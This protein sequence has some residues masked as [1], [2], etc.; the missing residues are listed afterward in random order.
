MFA[1]LAMHSTLLCVVQTFSPQALTQ[2]TPATNNI[3]PDNALER[4]EFESMSACCYSASW[5]GTADMLVVMDL[6]DSTIDPPYV[7]KQHPRMS[8]S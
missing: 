5:Y 2:F 4:P 3:A 8:P 7:D 1:S 6:E